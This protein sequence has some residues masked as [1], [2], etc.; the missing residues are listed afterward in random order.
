M[1]LPTTNSETVHS[2][3]HERKIEMVGTTIANYRIEEKLGEGGM[4][5]VYKAV[6]L[7]LDR[8]VAIKV[9][10]VELSRT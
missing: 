4:G 6:D 10:P 9:L 3:L 7:H 8:F 5:V 2:V 1:L